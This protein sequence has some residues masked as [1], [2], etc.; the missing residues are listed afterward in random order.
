MPLTSQASADQGLLGGGNT[1]AA[2][3]VTATRVLVKGEA[4]SPPAGRGDDFTWPRRSVA[5][6]GTDPVV[7][8]TTL[9]LPVMQAPG[10]ATTV[11]AP[12]ETPAV[13]AAVAPRR[14]A[15]R[16][17]ERES[18]RSGSP[19]GFFFPFFR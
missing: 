4:V 8:T 13:A 12:A 15:P 1:P 19:F 5:P 16:Q 9:P 18:R 3:H 6:F 11:S 2:A 10:P 17:A 7:A 14:S